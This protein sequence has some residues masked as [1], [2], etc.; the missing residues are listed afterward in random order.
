MS[1]DDTLREK[2]RRVVRAGT[3]PNRR[4]DHTWGGPGGGVRCVICNE[5]VGHDDVELEIEFAGDD[6]E[7]GPGVYRAHPRCFAIWETERHN[8]GA[9][10]EETSPRRRTGRSGPPAANAGSRSEQG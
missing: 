6:D 10:G 3:V 1:D 9:D 4:P 5:A 8:L 2:A 7:A